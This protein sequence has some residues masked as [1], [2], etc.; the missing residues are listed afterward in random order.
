M[1][2]ENLEKDGTSSTQR[3]EVKIEG[4]MT[5]EVALEEGWTG[6]ESQG[7]GHQWALEE[8]EASEVVVVHRWEALGVVRTS[9]GEIDSHLKE[10]GGMRCLHLRRG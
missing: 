3:G 2:S 7:Q 9:A 1:M 6:V 4:T 5:G 8:G 10:A